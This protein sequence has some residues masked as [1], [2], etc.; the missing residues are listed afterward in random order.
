MFEV[1]HFSLFNLFLSNY[2]LIRITSHYHLLVMIKRIFSLILLNIL[3]LLNIFQVSFAYFEEGEDADED[4][5]GLEGQRG[6]E[7]NKYKL[8]GGAESNE[9]KCESGEMDSV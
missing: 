6:I 1:C 8:L 3:K 7:D 9:C 5:K 2:L 4:G